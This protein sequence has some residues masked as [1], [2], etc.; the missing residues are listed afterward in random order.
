MRS[1]DEAFADHVRET[2]A[3]FEEGYEIGA[4]ERFRNQKMSRYNG[5]RFL[6][7]VTLAASTLFAMPLGNYVTIPGSYTLVEEEIA[8]LDEPVE[9][10]NAKQ[11]KMKYSYADKSEMECNTTQRPENENVPSLAS[12]EEPVSSPTVNEKLALKMAFLNELKDEGFDLNLPAV[13]YGSSL[14]HLNVEQIVYQNA[15]RP[16][17]N[18]LSM[19][20]TDS[21]GPI[22]IVSVSVSPGASISA[23]SGDGEFN[24]L[25]DHVTAEPVTPSDNRQEK[26]SEPD[27]SGST[28]YTQLALAS[29]Q[30][31]LELNEKIMLRPYVKIPFN[32]E[33]SLSQAGGNLQAGLGIAMAF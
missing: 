2:F 22:E 3:Q 32:A 19:V 18:G 10:Q 23:T 5:R 28:L 13:A 4:Y 21:P 17:V 11:C 29:I 30:M 14:V 15:I 26:E 31:D 33:L 27:K 12:R 25:E 1:F 8:C 20:N 24:V 9:L 16:T 6:T 7:L